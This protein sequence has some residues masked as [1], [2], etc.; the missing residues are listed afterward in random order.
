MFVASKG[1]GKSSPPKG[2]LAKRKRKRT[3]R[4]QA[5]GRTK[6]KGSLGAFLLALIAFVC[7]SVLPSTFDS[8]IA[9]PA[10]SLGMR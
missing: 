4:R 1:L 9:T 6:Q 5:S 8:L 2:E 7:H 10:T 3:V